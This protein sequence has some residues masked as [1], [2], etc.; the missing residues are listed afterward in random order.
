MTTMGSI[1]NVD[2]EGPEF[3][4]FAL[5]NTALLVC[6]QQIKE[7]MSKN[8]LCVNHSPLLPISDNT[9]FEVISD[10]SLITQYR[11]FFETCKAGTKITVVCRWLEGLNI[12]KY[13]LQFN[14]KLVTAADN[15]SEIVM[16]FVKE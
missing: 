13:L 9:A 12:S 1:I 11:N 7:L 4:Y 3:Y 6:S 15:E 2:L 5:K 10:P 14:I 8:I 16:Y